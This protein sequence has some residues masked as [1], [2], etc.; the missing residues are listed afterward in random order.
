MS[1]LVIDLGTSSVRASVVHPDATVSHVHS[2]ATL[3]DTPAAGI[4]EFDAAAYA[5][6]ALDCARRHLAPRRLPSAAPGNS[7]GGSSALFA[8]SGA[9]RS[10]L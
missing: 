3:P 7:R 9:D 6:A 8:S 4:V 10:A 2:T 5:A 1:I